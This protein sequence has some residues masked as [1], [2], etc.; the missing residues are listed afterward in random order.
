MPVPSAL[1]VYVISRVCKSV[2]VEPS[3]TA[4]CSVLTFVLSTVGSYTSDSTPSA[5]VYQTFETE[6]RAVPRQS[7][8]AR[9]KEEAAPGPPDAAGAVAAI[10][11]DPVTSRAKTAAD[12]SATGRR[13]GRVIRDL[14]GTGVPRRRRRRGWGARSRHGPDPREDP[15]RHPPA[16]SA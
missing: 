11:G 2:K 10:A 4:Y 13:V 6:S 3:V 7:L 14:I 5:T 9:S 16:A 15:G 8:R 12:A 1:T